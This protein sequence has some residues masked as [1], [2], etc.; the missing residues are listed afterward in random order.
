VDC[1]SF[2]CILDC[3]VTQPK[4]PHPTRGSPAMIPPMLPRRLQFSIPVGLNFLL[5][6]PQAL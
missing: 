3:A 6:P 1:G 2:E 5:T 4:R